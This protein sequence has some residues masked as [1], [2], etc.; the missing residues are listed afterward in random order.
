MNE[1]MHQI[2]HDEKWFVSQTNDVGLKTTR[3]LDA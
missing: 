1:W 3:F 2:W